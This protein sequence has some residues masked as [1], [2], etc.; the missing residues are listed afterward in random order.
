MQCTDT[1]DI[2]AIQ[3]VKT[4]TFSFVLSLSVGS[5]ES[6][7]LTERLH[8][9]SYPVGEGDPGESSV[10]NLVLWTGF[11]AYCKVRPGSQQELA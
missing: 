2:T 9:S 11:I 10:V 6:H 7:A 3:L 8:K 1:Q 5:G 4:V